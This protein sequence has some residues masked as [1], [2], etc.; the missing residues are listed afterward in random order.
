MRAP[1]LKVTIGISVLAHLLLLFATSPNPLPEPR[2]MKKLALGKLDN[3]RK[4]PVEEELSDP[5]PVQNIRPDTSPVKNTEPEAEQE[6][7]TEP[8]PANEPKPESKPEPMTSPQK[9]DK[10]KRGQ[11]EPT[12]V[13]PTKAGRHNN[14]GMETRPKKEFDPALSKR[15]QGIVRSRIEQMKSYPVSARRREQEG[16]IVVRFSV[17]RKGIITD[18]PE[19][20]KPSRYPVLNNAALKAVT[21][22]APFPPFNERTGPSI[23]TFRVPIKFSL[24]R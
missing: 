9:V 17:N 21:A 10:G 15:Y 22:A 6:P 7:A 14:K 16:T 24:R 3:D 11:I 13:E 5:Q 2:E 20:E 19:L 4:P 12:E 18:G 8:V 23:M 1:F